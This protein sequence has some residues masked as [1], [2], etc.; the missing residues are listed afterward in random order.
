MERLVM[1]P[2]GSGTLYPE[3]QIPED[4]DTLKHYSWQSELRPRT[5]AD[6][7]AGDVMAETEI[8]TSVEPAEKQSAKKAVKKKRN[9]KKK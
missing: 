2:N 6:V 9:G 7:N 4:E 8:K 5:P 1:T 3:D